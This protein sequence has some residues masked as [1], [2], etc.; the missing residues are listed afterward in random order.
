MTGDHAS[1]RCM[2]CHAPADLLAM[3]GVWACYACTQ[4]HAE[5]FANLRDRVLARIDAEDREGGDDDVL[6]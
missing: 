2:L 3:G 6:R 4:Q 5:Y 1:P